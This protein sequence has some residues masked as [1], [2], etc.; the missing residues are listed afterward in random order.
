MFRLTLRLALLPLLFTSAALFFIHAQPYDD[1][2]VHAFLQADGCTNICFMGIQPGVT[3]PQQALSQLRSTDMISRVGVSESL[4][5]VAWF[6]NKNR[7]SM[8]D[9]T[10][11]PSLFYDRDEI[12]SIRLYTRIRLGDLL[13]ELGPSGNHRVAIRQTVPYDSY[14]VDLYFLGSGYVLNAVVNCH[15]F[16]TQPTHLIIGS[17]PSFIASQT[18]ITSLSD[19][20]HRIAT[21]CRRRHEG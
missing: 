4:E 5:T 3:T 20:K 1:Q 8:M 12:S 17:T 2:V 21:A 7:S 16:W 10:Q 15:S 18:R 9:D 13:L 14:N 11:I 19:A 6:W